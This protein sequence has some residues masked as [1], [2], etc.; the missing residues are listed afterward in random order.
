MEECRRD[1]LLSVW[2]M[3]SCPDFVVKKNHL[4]RGGFIRCGNYI[5]GDGY[6]KSAS[7]GGTGAN[8]LKSVA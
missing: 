1:G 8:V 5:G 7:A 6:S 2:W 3:L 4:L